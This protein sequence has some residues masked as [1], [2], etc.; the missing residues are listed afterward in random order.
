MVPIGVK[1]EDLGGFAVNLNTILPPLKGDIDIKWVYTWSGRW[2]AFS[3]AF[4]KIWIQLYGDIFLD[5]MTH[6]LGKMQF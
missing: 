1:L 3:T 2:T 6:N 5:Y 4:M